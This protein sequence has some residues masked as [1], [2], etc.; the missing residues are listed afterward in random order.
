M[1]TQLIYGQ[2]HGGFRAVDLPTVFF[3]I[4]SIFLS[5]SDFGNFF[6]REILERKT[7]DEKFWRPKKFQ[8]KKMSSR[9]KFQEKN[10]GEQ[11]KFKKFF[12]H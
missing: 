7:F 4:F 10:F 3:F 9:K 2:A 12:Y 5:F 8:A 11:K 6:L 1:G